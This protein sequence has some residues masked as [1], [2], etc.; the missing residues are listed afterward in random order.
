MPRRAAVVGIGAG[1]LAGAAGAAGAAW[2]MASTSFS[3]TTLGASSVTI[4]AVKMSP[5][6]RSLIETF[7]P[8]RMIVALRFAAS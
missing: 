4:M 8:L 5:A 7:C 1:A 3:E 2:T 6:R